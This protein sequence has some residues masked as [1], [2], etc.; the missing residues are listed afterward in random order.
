M[1]NWISKTLEIARNVFGAVRTSETDPE[2]SAFKVVEQAFN[3]YSDYREEI[4]KLR[5]FYNGDQI[6][7]TGLNSGDYYI[8]DWPDEEE[9]EKT[10]RADRMAELAWNRVRDGVLT[11]ADALYASGVGVSVH[12]RIEWREWATATPEQQKWL[13]EYFAHRFWETNE[14]AHF[15]WDTWRVV[16][17]ERSA[18]V[19]NQWVDTRARRLRK[20]AKT[21]N[22]RQLHKDYGC[23]WMERLDNLQVIPVPHP[24]TPRELGGI[25]R[26][27]KRPISEDVPYTVMSDC[28]PGERDTITE[29][30][31]DDKWYR[32]MG[33][34][35]EQHQWGTDN[36]YGDVRTIFTWFRNAADIA[37]SEDSMAAQ[38]LLLENIYTGAEIARSHAFPETLY[39]GFEPPMR[40]DTATG[41]QILEKGPNVAYVAQDPNAEIKKVAA[42]AQLSDVGLNDTR[43]HSMLDEALGLSQ[44]ERNQAGGSGGLGQLRSAPALGRLQGRSERRRRRKILAADKA[45]RDLFRSVR[46]MTVFHAFPEPER[47]AFADS[48]VVV[49][50]PPEGF[51]LD[52]YTEAQK[53]QIETQAGLETRMEQL[54]KRHPE[55]SEADLEAMQTEIE[56][57]LESQKSPDRK[58]EPNAT[59][60]SNAQPEST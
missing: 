23:V 22:Q 4:Q 9:D 60:R 49:T 57:E 5:D 1:E 20:F 28:Y 14:I 55:A 3:D 41:R 54:R 13:E 24:N 58:P 51:G 12:R 50:W 15:M 34:K 59:L 32:W 39:A 19:M 47:Q 33:T 2:G 48:R 21:D 35:L 25:I 31:T 36:L 11:H 46:D 52:M 10:T 38:L 43:I 53:D 56:K 30:I 27:Y 45:E 26:W 8:P 16:G 17:G 6:Q 29:L 44:I 7:G 37:D 42:P 18:V 40:E